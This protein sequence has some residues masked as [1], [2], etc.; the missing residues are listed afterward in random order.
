MTES[1]PIVPPD[2]SVSDEPAS[3]EG[4]L[5]PTVAGTLDAVGA[6]V[7]LPADLIDAILLR[8]A[9]DYLPGSPVRE[10]WA[11]RDQTAEQANGVRQPATQ[12]Q[13]ELER[14]VVPGQRIFGRIAIVALALTDQA[15]AQAAQNTGLLAAQM[16]EIRETGLSLLTDFGVAML[17][18][19]APMVAFGHGAFEPTVELKMN[20]SATTALVAMARQ[21][22]IPQG[23][24]G[25]W[26]LGIGDK[27]YSGLGTASSE[28]DGLTAP[29]ALGWYRNGDLLAFTNLG[30][31]GEVIRARVTG[32][33]HA[34]VGPEGP[35]PVK[36][37]SA[38]GVV[39]GVSGTAS[40]S[41]AGDLLWGDPSVIS[42][43][44]STG[45]WTAVAMD[46]SATT[47]VRVAG[48]K[49]D[50]QL[51]AYFLDETVPAWS[52]SVPS[53]LNGLVAGGTTHVFLA[54]PN[55]TPVGTTNVTVVPWTDDPQVALRAIGPVPGQPQLLSA[56]G[57]YAAI[58]DG[59]A[60]TVVSPAAVVARRELPAAVIG[61]DL[62]PDGEALAV[63][64]ADQTLRMWR[65]S[66]VDDLSLSSYSNDNPD[67]PDLLGVSPTIDALA[68]LICAKVIAP[69]LS[70]GLFGAWGSGKSF[71]MRKLQARVDQVVED[72]QQ[73]GRVQRSLWAW[74]NISQVRFNAWDYS[75]GDVWAGL[76]EKLIHELANPHNG[77]LTLPAK[78]D[79]IKKRRLERMVAS[80]AAL[81]D[82]SKE[83]DKAEKELEGAV[84]ALDDARKDLVKGQKAIAEALAKAQ[85]R[86][87][88]G[89]LRAAV[90]KA[91]APLGVPEAAT[92]LEEVD[93]QL[94]AAR[95]RLQSAEGLVRAPNGWWIV[96]ALILA[97]LLAVGLGLLVHVIEPSLSG[98]VAFV[99]AL[100]TLL[101]G[102]ARWVQLGVTWVDERLKPIEEAERQAAKAHADLTAEVETAETARAKAASELTAAEDAVADSQRKLAEADK[103][104]AESTT[105]SLLN[106]YLATRST[107]ADYRSLLGVLGIVR[108]DLETISG[109]VTEHNEEVDGDE[110]VGTDD[111]VNRIVLYIDDLDRC[112]PDVVVKVLEAVHL[113]LSYPLFAVIVA[114][115]A[116]WVS[117]SL[118]SVY[119]TLLTG[120]D[121]TPDHYL[122][123]IFQLPMWLDSPSADAASQMLSGLLTPDVGQAGTAPQPAVQTPASASPTGVS[124]P[125]DPEPDRV[126]TSEADFAT[127]TPRELELTADEN[128]HI[129]ALAG[130]VCRSPR[131]VKRFINTYHLLKVI[132]GDPDELERVR[133]LLA[134]AVG[135][136][137]LGERLLSVIM[138]NQAPSR[139]LADIIEEQPPEDGAWF[140]AGIAL[141]RASW[142]A[143]TS[144]N[145]VVAAR[146]VHRF[147]YRAGELAAATGAVVV[148]TPGAGIWTGSVG[149]RR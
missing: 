101:V 36:W 15:V 90:K 29:I 28:V 72:A 144:D 135:R 44:D 8:H 37:P 113:L 126:V 17:R 68:A 52:V 124:R 66:P 64:C 11:A 60:V 6:G 35:P 59:R 71:F 120:G 147:V 146:H 110:F 10:V 40:V 82:V 111:V 119:P 46:R 104:V 75:S 134:V 87:V 106:E 139:R 74:R 105:G 50:N 89:T 58:S 92:A 42:V 131:A 137:I 118:A 125:A 26:A 107:S 62:S 116:Q 138:S 123:K 127:S 45:G 103:A 53:G 54:A 56:G 140:E 57:S 41:S 18:K 20:E 76:L 100:T 1:A 33:P 85:R 95:Q 24:V 23:Q 32:G 136:P 67:G 55:L 5:S 43:D 84:E 141:A 51:S 9:N 122:E 128:A 132:E 14:L 88:S 22:A 25:R 83:R 38:S 47:G 149:A 80:K 91:L 49:D 97:P 96:G 114:V 129:T 145:S 99:A 61:M 108:S 130:L 27:V 94:L 143:M 93:A 2:S 7:V 34:V 148:Q 98:V 121:V 112:R 115:D 13:A 48:V 63:L 117:R 78:L 109:A 39:Q 133:V 16:A 65:F 31:T 3:S 19:R 73:S 81:D 12:W 86:A 30:D 77:Q 21:D 79:E 142:I 70:V 69:P 102:V 4:R